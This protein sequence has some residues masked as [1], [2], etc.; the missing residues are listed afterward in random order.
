MAGILE[1]GTLWTTVSAAELA[2][3]H[4]DGVIQWEKTYGPVS[5]VGT[6]SPTDTYSGYIEI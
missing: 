2:I 1:E 4:R 3:E 5:Y 6:Y